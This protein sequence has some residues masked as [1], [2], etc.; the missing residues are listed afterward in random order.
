MP[1]LPF[2]VVCLAS[3]KGGSGKSTLAVHLAVAARDAGERVAVADLDPQGS[4]TF[5]SRARQAGDIPVEPT[6]PGELAAV[7]AEARAAG[8]SLVVLDTAPHATAGSAAAARLADLVL[9]PVR[10]ASFDLATA[11]Q[12]ARL[13]SANAKRA[14]F[15]LNA[16]RPRA[17]GAVGDAREVLA[18]LGVTVLDIQIGAR[19]DFETA[20]E[21]GRAVT[22][23]RP[24]SAAADEIRALWDW[25]ARQLDRKP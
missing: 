11:E 9:I 10:P 20:L 12:N 8:L 22:E 15:V 4:A 24:R 19:A 17:V 6:T 23:W 2:R 3:Q 7:L 21:T 5:W 18:A 25:C 16:C 14:A 13:A 1:D